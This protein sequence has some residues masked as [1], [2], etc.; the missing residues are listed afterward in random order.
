MF[1]PDFT[2]GLHLARLSEGVIGP[3]SSQSSPVMHSIFDWKTECQAR[4]PPGT[5]GL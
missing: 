2:T 5:E 4:N 3:Y 1:R